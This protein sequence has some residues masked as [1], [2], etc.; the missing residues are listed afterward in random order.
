MSNKTFK[1][2]GVKSGYLAFAA[3][4]LRGTIYIPK[5]LFAGEAPAEI[6]IAG[7]FAEPKAPTT[8]KVADP[9]KA[10]ERAE[11]AAAAAAKAQERASKLAEQAAQ[12]QAPSPAPATTEAP[13]V[14][15][16]TAAPAKS[17]TTK[18]SKAA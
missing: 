6:V 15:P 5:S 1:S 9:A 18:K 17:K 2:I 4:D 3:S 14:A 7:N 10:Q 16:T 13:A 8:P 12:M 11:R